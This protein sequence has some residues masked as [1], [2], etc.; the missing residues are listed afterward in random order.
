MPSAKVGDRVSVH[1]TGTLDDGT[2]FDSSRGAEPI[3]FTIGDDDLI[4]GFEQ[5]VIGMAPGETKKQSISCDQAYGPYMN[6]MVMD[7]DREVLPEDVEP[8]VGEQLNVEQEDGSN[9]QV[10]VLA[11]SDT[12]VKLDA[13]HPLAG[14]DLTFEIE[15][16]AVG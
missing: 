8:A 7:V 9:F 10:V 3:V 6:D 15:L 4:P 1:Y 11:V 14:K 5:A 16:V 13:N 12:K 2:V